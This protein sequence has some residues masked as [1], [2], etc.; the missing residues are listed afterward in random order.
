MV[1]LFHFPSPRVLHHMS[2]VLLVLQFLSP[3]GKLPKPLSPPT[4]CSEV[5]GFEKATPVLRGK[6]AGAGT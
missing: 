1:G 4:T 2:F 5:T 3:V 6:R